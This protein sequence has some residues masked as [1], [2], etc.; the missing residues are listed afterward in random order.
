MS[1][2]E[3]ALVDANSSGTVDWRLALF[4]S[5]SS[6]AISIKRRLRKE[7]VDDDVE[8]EAVCKEHAAESCGSRS[9]LAAVI[10]KIVS[11]GEKRSVTALKCTAERAREDQ[12]QNSHRHRQNGRSY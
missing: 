6:S 4:S 5:S 9:S 12:R 10:S 2:I 3:G 8:P 11:C 1:A 7:L